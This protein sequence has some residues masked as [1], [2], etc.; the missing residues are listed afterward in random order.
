MFSNNHLSTTETKASP[1]FTN[2]KWRVQLVQG[3]N[4]GVCVCVC[5]LLTCE[6]WNS[7]REYTY[8]HIYTCMYNTNIINI[9]FNPSC[10]RRLFADIHFY[11]TR[12]R[13]HNNRSCRFC[14][15][16]KAYYV[17]TRAKPK[18]ELTKLSSFKFFF[19]WFYVTRRTWRTIIFRKFQANNSRGK[20][21]KSK[22]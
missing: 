11:V 19:A 17:L 4:L 22:F 7:K 15:V 12:A 5:L 14:H 21:L 8:I 9:S 2:L 18:T 13:I 10:R 16:C 20:G 1:R 3:K 6:C